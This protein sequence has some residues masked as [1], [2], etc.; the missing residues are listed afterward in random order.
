MKKTNW[1][2]AHLGFIYALFGATYAV[3]ATFMVTTL[4][5]EHGFSEQVAG[6]FW[7]VVG[8]LS[9]VSGPLFGW[10]SDRLGRRTGMLM[11]FTLFTIV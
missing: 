1:I 10:I 9:I 3:Y 6:N 7:A 8:T 2:T 11:V 5:D 4:V